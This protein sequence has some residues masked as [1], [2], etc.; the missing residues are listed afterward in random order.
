MG[1]AT[2]ESRSGRAWSRAE[3]AYAVTLFVVAVWLVGLSV[4]RNPELPAGR[5]VGTALFFLAYGIFT[6]SIGYQHPRFGYY[7]FDRVSQV[8]SILVLGPV[9]AAWINGLASFIYPWHRLWKGVPPHEVLYAALN[10]SGLMS[11]IVLLSGSLYVVLGGAIPLEALGGTMLVPLVVLVLAMQLL[12]D[13]GMLGLLRLAGQSLKG[14]FNSFSYALELGAGATAVLVAIVYNT[15]QPQ[16]FALLVGVLGLG[17]LALRQFANMRHQL[18]LIVSERTKSLR[19]KTRQLEQLA[20]EDKLTGLYNRRFADEYL[21]Q[22]LTRAR[23]YTEAFSVALADVDLFKRINDEHSHAAGDAVLRRIAEILRERCRGTDMISRYGG[24]EFLICFP[25][26][27]AERARQLCEDLRA[28]VAEASWSELGLAGAVTI[29][30]GVA[31]LR[32]GGAREALLAE[33]DLR[34]YRAKQRG[35]NLVVA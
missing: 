31:E 9:H 1:P 12:N 23:R 19:E 27:D 4:L 32:S 10:N 20:T 34:L 28:A 22:Q 8:A 6:I 2:E 18:E 30:F 35:R 24:E 11:L 16:A 17:M 7:S 26:T 29:S 15:M 33:A 3:I 14:F 5:G 25:H 13:I 21:E